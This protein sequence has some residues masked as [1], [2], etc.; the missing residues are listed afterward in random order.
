MRH[1]PHGGLFSEDKMA[2]KPQ[3]WEENI[4]ILAFLNILGHQ[5]P[6]FLVLMAGKTKGIEKVY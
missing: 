4:W 1:R 6:R 2:V 5:D 3:K